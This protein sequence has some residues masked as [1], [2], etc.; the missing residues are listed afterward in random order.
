MSELFQVRNMKYNLRNGRILVS[1]NS[2]TECYGKG[3]ISYLAPI[4]GNQVPEGI[5]NSKSVNFFANKIKQ[6]V[7]VLFWKIQYIIPYILPYIISYIIQYI[8]TYIMRYIIPY[9]IQYIVQYILPYI[10]S[11][12]IPY[13]ITYTIP[14]II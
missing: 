13:I 10:I 8:I 11:F 7:P 4:R 12:I 1:S 14:Y 5:K 2:K 9:I 6:W 3:C